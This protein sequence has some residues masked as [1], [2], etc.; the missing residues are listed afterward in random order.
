MSTITDADDD[1]LEI[2]LPEVDGRDLDRELSDGKAGQ[3]GI[4]VDARC[5]GCKRLRAKYV[6]NRD[7]ED[8]T[9]FKTACH[10]C[11]RVTWWNVIRVLE[12]PAD[13]NGGEQA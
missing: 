3:R 13:E 2:D 4:A 5:I 10:Q 6:P 12:H 11:R 7:P 8:T 1:E 9:S